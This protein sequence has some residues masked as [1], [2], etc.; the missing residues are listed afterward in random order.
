MALCRNF[1]FFRPVKPVSEAQEL[2]NHVQMASIVAGVCGANST[3]IRLETPK[4]RSIECH[5]KFR[6]GQLPFNHSIHFLFVMVRNVCG[7]YKSQ[8]YPSNH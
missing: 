1:E 5:M 6:T 7:G 8:F 3:E 2:L 4:L